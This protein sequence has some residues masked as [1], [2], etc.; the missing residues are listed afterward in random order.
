MPAK[1]EW[2][3]ALVLPLNLT[4]LAWYMLSS[5]SESAANTT[6]PSYLKLWCFYFILDAIYGHLFHTILLVPAR[7]IARRLPGAVVPSSNNEEKKLV[8]Q[9]ESSND[10]SLDWPSADAIAKL[11][12]D[13]VAVVSTSKQDKEMIETAGDVSERSVVSKSSEKKRIKS[14]NSKQRSSDQQSNNTQSSDHKSTGTTNN[15]STAQQPY[16]L[17]HVR[18]STRIRQASQRIGAAM[19]SILH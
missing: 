4:L 15:N 18:G 5:S 11:P 10:V 9:E 8:E 6:T 2:A 16:Y 1:T 14:K 19:G 12:S 3:V 7:W 17:N 13:W